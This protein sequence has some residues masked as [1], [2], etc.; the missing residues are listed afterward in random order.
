MSTD[1]VTNWGKVEALQGPLGK[2][3]PIVIQGDIYLIWGGKRDSHKLR[4]IV[5]DPLD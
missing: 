3:F 1:Y 4:L 2:P 5:H